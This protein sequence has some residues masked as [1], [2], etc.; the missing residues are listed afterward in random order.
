MVKPVSDN[1]REALN[2]VE[3]VMPQQDGAKNADALR[4][5]IKAAYG[6]NLYPDDV[7]ELIQETDLRG[8]ENLRGFIEREFEVLE[9]TQL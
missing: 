9:S 4:Q 2:H 5:L 1:V 8:R 6:H 7:F 3:E